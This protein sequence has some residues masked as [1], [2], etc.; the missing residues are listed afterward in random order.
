M[1]IAAESTHWYRRDGAPAYTVI[2]A[3]GKER[4]TTLRDARKLDLVPSVSTV[5]KI[6]ASYGLVQYQLKQVL[7]CALTLPMVPGESLDAYGQ[8]VMV[9]AGEHARQAAQRGR[10]IHEAIERYFTD[11]RCPK[12]EYW[13][14]VEAVLEELDRLGALP[15]QAMAEKSFCS[16]L[17]YGGK[18]DLHTPVAVI[19]FKT[20][21]FD[22]D[23][24]ASKLTWDDHGIQLAAYRH[25]LRL[26][27]ARLINIYLSTSNPGLVRSFE[28]DHGDKLW[29]RFRARFDL[30]C[31][32]N[33]YQPAMG[34]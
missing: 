27:G 28:W 13:P 15:Q 11:G 2:G 1:T 9:D 5:Q 24:K 6:K 18:V 19:D 26:P 21:E 3:N 14:H 12:A 23:A 4:P 22:P 32:E 25:G 33:D 34:E 7:Q 17:G 29:R 30:W 31:V 16:P 20:K 8:R 10:D